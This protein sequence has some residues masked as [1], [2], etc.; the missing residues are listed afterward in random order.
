MVFLTALSWITASVAP[1]FPDM[2]QLINV[3]M[4]VLMWMLPILWSQNQFPPIVI[5]ILKI[6]PLYYIVQG[7]RESFLSQAWFWNHPAMTLYFWG[8]MIILLFVGSKVFNNLRPHFS[9]VL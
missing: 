9:V 2:S 5:S 3:I 1:F 7:Y 8:A 6:N 4:Q